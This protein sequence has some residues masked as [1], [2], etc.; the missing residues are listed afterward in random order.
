M[1]KNSVS[2]FH[3]QFLWVR[4]VVLPATFLI[5][6]THA[7]KFAEYSDSLGRF[8]LIAMLIAVVIFMEKLL[9]PNRGLNPKAET[10]WWRLWLTQLSLLC[11]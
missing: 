7:S 8:S 3:S 1:A 9:H 2:L 10:V 6:A 4:F 5:H 11:H